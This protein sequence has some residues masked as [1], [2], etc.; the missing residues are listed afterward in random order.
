[1][2]RQLASRR[3]VL[4]GGMVTLVGLAGCSDSDNGGSF[5]DDDED[6]ATPGDDSDDTTGTG[7]ADGDG[8]DTDGGDGE[9]T[10]DETE[11]GDDEDDEGEAVPDG[12]AQI[13]D[14]FTWQDNY[15]ME[16]SAAEASGT[17][18]VADDNVRV[19]TVLDT[20]EVHESYIIGNDIYMIMGGE[21]HH[22]PGSEEPDTVETDT[23]EDAGTITSSGTTTIDGQEVYIFEHAE[24]TWYISVATGY[25]VRLEMEGT[26]VDYHSWGD[27]G[28]IEPPADCA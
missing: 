17:Q 15:V 25:P 11:A 18:W 22:L 8:T 28:P 3:A 27:V 10:G 23:P 14:V 19:E 1:M 4:V 21:C 12:E 20:G 7:D 16:F 9:D 26:T 13:Q 2:E 6:D 5:G 24:G